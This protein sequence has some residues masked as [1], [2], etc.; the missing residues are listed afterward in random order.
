MQQ[1]QK[2]P[3]SWKR[4]LAV[5]WLAQSCVATGFTFSFP[6]VPLFLQDMDLAEGGQA[7]LWAAIIQMSMAMAMILSGPFW[8]LV[9]DRY[10]RKLNVMRGMF[11]GGMAFFL[12]AFSTQ[13]YHLIITRFLTG[14][15]TGS[16]GPAMAL[17]ASTT[18]RERI[19]LSMGILQTAFF[20]G[21]T[22]GPLLGGLVADSWGLKGTFLVSGAMLSVG[23][24]I[25]LLFVQE[26]FHRPSES[27]SVFQ[28][29]AYTNLLR[30]LT[31]RELMPIFVTILAVQ[32]LPIMGFSV[33]PVIL[34]DLTSLGGG[35]VTGVAFG[36]M[37][38]TGGVG[39]Y[40]AG[41]ASRK[42][43]PTRILRIAVAGAA[44]SFAALFVADS[45]AQFYVLLAF[46]GASQGVMFAMTGS[47]VALAVSG[48]QQ[49]VAFGGLQAVQVTAFSGGQMI[50]GV[51]GATA[52]LRWVFPVQAAGLL[53]LLVLMARLLPEG[54]MSGPQGA[55]AM[56]AEAAGHADSDRAPD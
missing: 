45:V 31:S 46:A 3:I 13:L 12:S 35:S 34:D 50:G 2:H 18:P 1:P 22:I 16:I 29:Q 51:I 23:G 11:G 39:S 56:T 9:G 26:E 4:N 24:V 8:G 30:L 53:I 6:F 40:L 32:G 48:E 5:L 52:G 21:S 33:L 38:L 10:G 43:T 28:R 47:L 14:L 15:L 55:V 42:A 44:L 19:P 37:G 17:V 49:G 27:V 41:L 25:A 20:V 36:V 7:A 54:A